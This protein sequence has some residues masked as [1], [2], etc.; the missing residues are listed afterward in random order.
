[1]ITV[2]DGGQ[3]GERTGM[4]AADRG[5]PLVWMDLEM[6]GLDPGLCTIIEIATLV[7]DSELNLI[8]EGPE[9]AIHQSDQVLEAMDAWNTEH[10]TASGLAD[11]VRQSDVDLAEA[12]RQTL[13]F[14]RQHC[15]AGASNLCGNSIAQ[16]RRFLRR[17]MPEL[18]A[19]FHY[20]LVDVSTIKVLVRAWYP[21]EFH[22]PPKKEAHRARG[23]ILESIAEL[24]HYRERVFRPPPGRA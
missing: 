6:T 15:R 19:F 9:L 20:R 8:A 13:E 24:K 4:S 5:E 18:D 23:D 2:T 11:R 22:A 1:M 14:L 21:E 17:Y 16:D 7:T 10:H 12:E 3:S